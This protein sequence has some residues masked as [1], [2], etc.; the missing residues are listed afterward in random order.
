MESFHAEV[1]L[2]VPG[3]TTPGSRNSVEPTNCAP[4][5]SFDTR[6]EELAELP[7]TVCRLVD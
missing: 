4:G 3:G 1:R 6:D 2:V 7:G 5:G